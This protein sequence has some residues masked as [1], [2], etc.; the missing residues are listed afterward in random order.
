M[1]ELSVYERQQAVQATKW[2]PYVRTD[3][4]EQQFAGLLEAPASQADRRAPA[5]L[6]LLGAP[7]SG[8]TS[9]LKHFSAR[10]PPHTTPAGQVRCPVLYVQAPAEPDENRLYETILEELNVDY[11]PSG[12]TAHNCHV[13]FTHLRQAQVRL[14]LLDDVHRVLLPRPTQR[15]TQ[16]AR[17]FQAVLCHLV[18]QSQ[19][20]WVFAGDYPVGK[21]I[22]NNPGLAE[23]FTP[24]LLPELTMDAAYLQLLAG[25]EESL[26]LQKKSDLTAPD[27]AA[28]LLTRS[29][30]NLEQLSDMLKRAAEVAIGAGGERITRALLDNLE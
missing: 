14:L 17:Q 10:Y 20:P 24:V 27:V 7:G 30:G 28:Y 16:R 8:K 26:S 23:Q 3:Q 13:M 18:E 9:V 1:G 6:L 19:Q 4:L 2:V 12:S 15:A 11:K 5:N 21:T 25:L 22:F 29:G